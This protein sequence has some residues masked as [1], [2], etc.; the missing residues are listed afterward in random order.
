MAKKKQ[1]ADIFTKAK[2][3]H[4]MSLI[5]SRG[6]KDTEVVLAKMLRRHKITGWR[7][8]L[9]I[10]VATRVASSKLSVESRKKSKPERGTPRTN[11]SQPSTKTSQLTLTV[12]PDFVFTKSRVAVFVDGCFWHGCP[13]HGTKPKGNRAFWKNKFATN[14]A[15]DQRVNLALR[16]AKWRVLRIWEH[17]LKQEPRLLKRLTLKLV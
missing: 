16:S 9:L 5:R 13:I 7:R 17:E 14:I 10:R 6:N 3:S 1:M 11:N 2:R 8:H 4:V 12:R 15:R